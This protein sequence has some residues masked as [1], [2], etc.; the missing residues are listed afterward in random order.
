MERIAAAF[1]AAWSMIALAVALRA[2]DDTSQPDAAMPVVLHLDARAPWEAIGPGVR[3]CR[4][5]TDDERRLIVRLGPQAVSTMR[6]RLRMAA[7]AEAAQRWPV[8]LREPF[9]VTVDFSDLEYGRRSS[10]TVE[11]S[12]TDAR[13]RTHRVRGSLPDRPDQAR[14]L[15]TLSLPTSNAQDIVE[16]G[17]FADGLDPLATN[18]GT[19]A[20]SIDRLVLC[21]AGRQRP[22]LPPEGPLVATLAAASAWRIDSVQRGVEAFELADDT[23]ILT[24]RLDWK[25]RHRRTGAVWIDV[26]NA[27]LPV[28]MSRSGV[29]TA[30][31]CRRADATAPLANFRISTGMRDVDGNVFWG[32]GYEVTA[33]GRP[34]T[35][36]SYPETRFPLPGGFLAER[37]DPTRVTAVGVRLDVLD[38]KRRSF[39][40]PV[41]VAAPRIVALPA[42]LRTRRQRIAEKIG[43]A[44][45]MNTLAAQRDTRPVAQVPLASFCENVGVNYPWPR[46]FYAGL[47]QRLGDSTQGGFSTCVDGIVED[48]EY[49][50]RHEVKLVRVFLFCDGRC[51]LVS[52]GRGG[53]TLDPLVLP[54]LR[55]LL[56]ASEKTESLR[57]VPVLFDFLLADG[58]ERESFG[59]VGEHPDWIR[60]D[61]T[62]W[63]LLDAVQP[64]IDLLCTHPRVAFIDLMNEPEHAAAVDADELWTF[65]SELAERVHRNPRGVR[66]TVGSANA[67]YAPFWLSTG[68][69]FPTCHWFEKTDATHK[70][71]QHSAALDPGTT[72]LTEIDPTVGVKTALTGVWQAGFRGGLFWSL[73]GDDAYAFR[74]TAAEAFKAWVDEHFPRR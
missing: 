32:K 63:A 45:W 15:V 53:L 2:Q 37:F 18:A 44:N 24:C 68:I 40:G 50:A 17:V 26:T 39:S 8:A 41:T 59:L 7:L 36:G 48:F 67:V 6:I 56:A 22:S 33:D 49:L 65:L 38:D 70:L 31:G 42:E 47:G 61:R 64:A 14:Q 23:A 21:A 34:V 9:E 73:N 43:R 1:V 20:I 60:D 10:P 4:P 74:G 58:V 35:T 29:F 71:G 54:D 13:W 52:D 55:A 12:V 28:D 5:H 69:D 46:G 19:I 30:A 11:L 25:D 62:R 3:D 51:G 16:L 27:G 57:L 72:L 66:C